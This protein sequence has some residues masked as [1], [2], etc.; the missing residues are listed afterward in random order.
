M[1]VTTT[2]APIQRSPVASGVAAARGVASRE[3]G[4]VAVGLGGVAVAVTCAAGAIG[5]GRAGPPEGGVGGGATFDFGVGVFTLTVA[6]LLPFAG[7]T[8]AARGRWRR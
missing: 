4:L 3:P 8:D 1:P 7:Y 5:G 6:A 2:S